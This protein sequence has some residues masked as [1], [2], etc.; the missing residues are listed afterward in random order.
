MQQSLQYLF[1]ACMDRDM[2]VPHLYIKNFKYNFVNKY[3]V[4]YKCTIAEQENCNVIKW[5]IEMKKIECFDE[6]KELIS[7]NK[8]HY[9]KIKSNCFLLLDNIKHYIGQGRMYYENLDGGD[10]VYVDE[11]RYCNAYY[12]WGVDYLQQFPRLDKDKTICIEEIDVN[13]RRKADIDDMNSVLLKQGFQARPVNHEIILELEAHN[14]K[15]RQCFREDLRKL[16]EQGLRL[17]DADEK[18][19]EQICSLW[20]ASLAPTDLPYDHLNFRKYEDDKVVCLINAEELVCGATWW[21]DG[22][23]IRDGRHIVVNPLY[24]RRGLGDALLHAWLVD[25]LNC[26]MNRARTWVADNNTKSDIMHGKAGFIHS[27]KNSTQYIL[28]AK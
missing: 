13:N 18:Y 14:E 9:G 10:I 8:R 21:H 26:G 1:L 15:L 11:V 3:M 27:G 19:A 23:K 24:R 20:E 2:I 28:E 5:G 25:A 22:K 7:E 16:E 17:V 4:F 6:Y 12:F